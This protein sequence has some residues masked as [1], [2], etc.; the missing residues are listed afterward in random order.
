MTAIGCG[1]KAYSMNR[2][3]NSGAAN[4]EEKARI[5]GRMRNTGAAT[6]TLLTIIGGYISLRSRREDE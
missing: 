5:Y 3:I 2:M 1:L 6:A 4:L